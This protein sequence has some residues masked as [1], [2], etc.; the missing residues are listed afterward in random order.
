MPGQGDLR[1]GRRDML[2]PEIARVAR[3]VEG[4]IRD[5][6]SKVLELGIEHALSGSLEPARHRD[7]VGK[8][9]RAALRQLAFEIEHMPWAGR[10]EDDSP[11]ARI[12]RIGIAVLGAETDERVLAR[13]DGAV[14]I[15]DTHFVLPSGTLKPAPALIVSPKGI[16]SLSM[17]ELF[18]RSV[19]ILFAGVVGFAGIA[20]AQP[21]P[22]GDPP[23]RVGRLAFIQGTVSF[24]DREQ[25]DWAP[26]VANRPLTSGDAIWT[27]PSARSEISIAGTRVRM[28]S[29]TQLDMLMI[30]D[31]QTRMQVDRGRLDIKT[32]TYDTPQPHQGLP[33]PRT[34]TLPAPGD[35]H[36]SAGSPP[37]PPPPCPPS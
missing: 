27:E 28:D 31:S 11:E 35:Y 10:T 19:A 12:G 36:V 18:R 4:R 22:S 5:R 34:P 21:G 8:D 7:V 1:V 25:S 2:G 33:P 20:S 37:R 14:G 24:H 17:V 32:F 23:G 16:R 15:G 3:L 26:A 6:D 13:Q 9:A 29:A 30:D